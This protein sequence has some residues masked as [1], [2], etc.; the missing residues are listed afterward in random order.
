MA[1]IRAIRNK[2]YLEEFQIEGGSIIETIREI[3]DNKI[4]GVE[5]KQQ[6]HQSQQIQNKSKQ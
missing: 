1:D 3:K 2:T 6:Q 5:K 4:G